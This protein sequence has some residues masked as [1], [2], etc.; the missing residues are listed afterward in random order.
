MPIWKEEGPRPGVVVL[1][2]PKS[3]LEVTIEEDGGMSV[4]GERP[5]AGKRLKRS[6]QLILFEGLK[7]SIPSS[8]CFVSRV[9]GAVIINGVDF[10]FSSNVTTLFSSYGHFP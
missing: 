5:A 3:L 6:P 9:I 2:F 4:D 8:S 1:G 7:V 10:I